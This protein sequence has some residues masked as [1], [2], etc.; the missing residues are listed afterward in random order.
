MCLGI[1]GLILKVSTGADE[2]DNMASVDFGGVLRE[3]SLAAV[4]DAVPGEYVVVHA[5]FA[6]SR[7][8]K[9]EA[10]RVIGYLDRLK[11]LR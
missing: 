3:V 4:P 2:L 11:D 7:L 5:G 10:D 9:D 1:P 6:L 8:K